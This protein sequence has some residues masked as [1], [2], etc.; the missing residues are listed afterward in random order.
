MSQVDIII[1]V[2]QEN[3]PDRFYECIKSLFKNT[4]DFNLILVTSGD[5]QPININRGLERAKSEFIAILDWDVVVPGRWLHI[6]TK[7]LKDDKTIGIIG[8]RMIGGYVGTNRNADLGVHDWDTL[9]GG[10]VV[11]RNLGLRWDENFPSGYWADTDFCRQFREN[12]YK[13]CING[14]VDVEHNPNT[15]G[16]QKDKV[17]EWSDQGEKVYKKKWGNL[18]F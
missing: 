7:N 8:A 1:P 2:Y 15:F 18:G 11:F 17:I 16:T 9:A 14:D 4:K 3:I 12:G 10:C 6:L 5:P 13:V